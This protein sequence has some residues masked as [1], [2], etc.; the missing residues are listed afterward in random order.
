MLKTPLNYTGGKYRMLN[1]LKELFPKKCEVFYD[2]FAGGGDIF[3]NA[4]NLIECEKIHANEILEQVVEIYREMQENE[5]M[6][7]EIIDVIK[8]YELS[9][10]NKEGYLKL[11][12]DYNKSVNKTAIMFY[13]LIVHSFNNQI[14]FNKKGDYNMPFGKDR[15]SFNNALQK[16]F[17]EFS[18]AIKNK[19]YIITCEDYSSISP[20]KE[21]FIYLDPPYL[22]STATYNENGDWSE[23][24][25][26][27]LLEYLEALDGQGVRFGLSNVIEHKGVE[28]KLLKEYIKKNNWRLHYIDID[29]S[30]CSY[31]KKGKKSKTVEVY[32]CNY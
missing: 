1:R 7:S 15:S 22:I 32:V 5:T 20:T 11:R 29:Y 13:A 8:E 21:D 6:Y 2:A 27:R 23:K 3:I 30:N 17:K 24:E 12:E 16:K 28:N 10:T 31:H 19:K 9:K 4:D 25:E 18:K 26:K 14:R